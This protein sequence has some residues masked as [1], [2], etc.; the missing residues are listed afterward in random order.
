MLYHISYHMS[1]HI[2]YYISYH[3]SYHNNNNSRTFILRLIMQCK[4][5]GAGHCSWARRITS[6]LW[7]IA[8]AF[9]PVRQGTILTN[10]RVIGIATNI[11]M[12]LCCALVT[13]PMMTAEVGL[14]N[15]VYRHTQDVYHK[16]C[17]YHVEQTSS[18]FY[19]LFEDL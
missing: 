19:R 7:H 14:P 8:E 16:S 1:Y 17:R 10:H 4:L 18:S 2:S 9:L 12:V 13:Y 3:I 11:S 15:V 6:I 5:R